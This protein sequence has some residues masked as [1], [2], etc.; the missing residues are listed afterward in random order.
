MNSSGRADLDG[1][2]GRLQVALGLGLC[3]AGLLVRIRGH[4]ASALLCLTRSTREL[5]SCPV[6]GILQEQG[7]IVSS[8]KNL[9][10]R[11]SA[12]PQ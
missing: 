10:C 3:L 9:A 1:I 8:Q 5:V 11:M 7:S 12:Q 2:S 4:G 6:V